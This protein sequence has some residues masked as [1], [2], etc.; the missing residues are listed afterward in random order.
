MSKSSMTAVALVLVMVASAF[1]VATVNVAANKGTRDSFGYAWTDSKSPSPSVAFNWVEISS[2]GTLSGVDG[3]DYCDGPFSIGFNFNFYGNR[4]SAFNISTNGY[5]IFGS[6]YDDLSPDNIPYSGGPNNFIAIYW[7]DMYMDA[8]SGHGIYYQT[9]GVAPDRQLVVEYLN[10]SDLSS[11]ST[12]MTMQIIITESGEIW[13]QYLYLNGVLGS[14]AGVGIENSGGTVGCQYSHDTASLQDNLAIR[15]SVSPVVIGPSSTMTGKPGATLSYTLTVTNKMATADSFAIRTTSVEG[16]PVS[17]LSS[18]WSA[19]TDSDLDG[20]PD[21]GTLA[22]GASATIHVNVSVPVAPAN[23]V[24]YTAVNASAHSNALLYDVCVLTSNEGAAWFDP[25]HSSFGTDSDSNGD[26]NTLTV[27]ASV[28]C[29]VAGT[30]YVEAYLYTYSGYYIGYQSGWATLTTGSGMIQMTWNGWAIREMGD[31]GELQVNM[32][33][34][35]DMYVQMDDDVYFT[36]YY[37]ATDFMLRPGLFDPPHSDTATDTDSD[38]LYERLT[39]HAGV[40]A[41][42]DGQFRVDISMY[43]YG[44]SYLLG[45]SVYANLPAG[46]GTVNFTIDSKELR[47]TMPDDGPYYFYLYL[48]AFV[49]GSWVYVDSDTYTTAWYNAAEFEPPDALLTGPHSDSAA[50]TDSDGLYEYLYIDVNVNVTVAGN[51]TVTGDLSIWYS[52]LDTVFNT[53]YLS[54]GDHVV[55]LAF[56]GYPIRNHGDSDQVD[57]DITLTGDSG[58]LDTDTYSS[59]TYYYYYDFDV[60]PGWFVTPYVYDVYD[61]D[62]D[63]LYD[64]LLANVT[65]NVTQDGIYEVRADLLDTWDDLIVSFSNETYLTAGL[66]E[67][68]FAFPGWMIRE[69]GYNPRE[70]DLFLYDEDGREMDTDYFYPSGYS[71]TSFEAAPAQFGS[72][73]NTLYPRDDDADGLNDTMVM[74]VNVTAAAAGLYIVEGLLYDSSWTVVGHERT[75]VWLSAGSHMVVVEYP[76]WLIHAIAAN[77]TYWCYSYLHDAEMH[78]MDFRSFSGGSWVNVFNGTVPRILSAWTTSP[79]SANGVIGSSE[80]AGATLVDM[81]TLDS[82]NMLDGEMLVMNDETTLYICFDVYGDTTDNDYDGSSIAFDTG[83]DEVS[84]VGDEDEFNLYAYGWKAH[85][86]FASGSSWQYDCDFDEGL[87]DHEGLLGAAGFGNTPTYAY[88]HRVFEFAIPLSLLGATMWDVLGFMTASH[89]IDG[90]HD[91]E[92][93]TYSAWPLL[94]STHLLAA[95]GDLALSSNGTPPP[96]VTTHSL[97][98]TVGGGGWYT[99]AVNVTLN[100]TGGDGGVDH[101]EYSV[102]SGIWMT[103]SGPIM[104]QTDGNHI[105]RYRSEDAAHHMEGTKAVSFNIDRSPPVTATGRSGTT[106]WLNATDSNSGVSNTVYRVD[107]GS[108]FSYAG[109]FSAGSGAVGHTVEFYSTDVAGNDESVK[110][111]NVLPAPPVTTATLEGIMGGDGWYTSAVN[112]TLSA[113]GGSGGLDYTEYL[114][115]TG[116]WVTYTGVVVVATNGTHSISYRSVDMDGQVEGAKTTNFMIDSVAP[117]TVS[118]RSGSW[119]WL[120]SSDA[121]SGVERIVYRVDA[122]TWTN[123]SGSFTVG[124]GSH[125]VEF[126][127]IDHAGNTESVKTAT[128]VSPPVTTIALAGTVGS[129]GWYKTAVTITLSATGGSGGVD[130]TEYSLDGAAWV[131]YIGPIAVETGG[132]HSIRYMSTDGTSQVEAM[133]TSNFKIDTA[134]PATLSGKSGTWIWLNSTDAH[135]GVSSIVYRIDGGDWTLYIG[136]VNVTGEKGSHTVEFYATD[137]AGNAETIQSITVKIGKSGIS[138][139]LTNPILWIG[140]IA[141]IAVLVVVVLLVT[142]RRRGQ[143]PVMYPGPGQPMPAQPQPMPEYPPPPAPPGMG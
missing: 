58:Q 83:N 44:W 128:T 69:N 138:G 132:A 41:N 118:G 81:S 10:F 38:G 90:L 129:V 63:G 61:S 141:A 107:G 1:A 91:D 85:Y 27:N 93:G 77:G 30:Y 104:V 120:N 100:A 111:L 70:I 59:S 95:Y 53:T 8:S 4:Y 137:V 25:P 23:P 142:K 37:A 51:Y 56:P 67:F 78:D 135:S 109:P 92:N 48:Y 115:D 11:T 14:N 112:V 76:G 6:S 96:P 45:K 62:G 140:L 31:D 12:H 125:T 22:S 143:Q 127:A 106:V 103:Y 71:Y 57:I 133:K 60:A 65:V 46:S 21:T 119:I 40:L 47:L 134:A 113:T 35:D 50:D 29:R 130:H 117:V 55:R 99:S 74:E 36:Q 33:L 87:I 15:Y 122:G 131:N 39:L 72:V 3:D 94:V 52:Y 32:Q 126:Y 80:W 18:S 79:P 73:G 16:W 84:T 54:V 124:A 42:Y 105:V 24:E 101:T 116:S 66:H 86:S 28:Y 123:Y 75:A 98:G 136:K 7:H 64:W 121:N 26:Y 139:L 97:D 110:T 9:M 17:I 88:H 102:D 5:I 34:Y 19:L 13:M 68:R 89:S 114:L 2:T 20:W 49:R 108:W 43:D 82:M